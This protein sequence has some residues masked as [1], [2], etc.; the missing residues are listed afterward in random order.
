MSGTGQV[1][2]ANSSNASITT[3]PKRH[4][5][6]LDGLRGVAAITVVIFHLC[7]VYSYGNRLKLIPG[8]AYLAVDFFYLLSG[9]V[10]A[11]AYDDRWARMSQ[12]DFYKRRLIRLQPMVIL[13]T[14]IGAAL[15]YFPAGQRYPQIATT[16]VWQVLLLM[17]MGYVMLPVPIPYR[18][19]VKQEMFPLDL[20]V[21]SLFYEYIANVLYAV[22]LRRLS[23]RALGVLVFFCGI[24]LVQLAVFG[25][26]GDLIGGW[27]VA[28]N[29][30]YF[31]MVR[32]LF[33]FFAGI[34]LMRCG[35]RIHVKG[36]F[37]ICNALLLLALCMPRIG[38]AEHLWQ[39]GV[40]E[41][42]CVIV[43]FP[44]IVAMG[45]SERITDGVAIWLSRF[46]G[47]LSYPLYVTHVPLILIF[48]TWVVDHK[49][50]AARGAVVGTFVFLASVALAYAS[51]KL[52][53]EPVR[54]WLGRRFLPRA[55]KASGG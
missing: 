22:G 13:G 28:P 27:T 2:A 21:W 39:N 15:F 48:T 1:Q 10:V 8:H 19:H 6:I 55:Q 32:L 4:Y 45:A 37:W 31:G 52:Y 35:L 36:A 54:R 16:P 50:P 24:L 51:L 23:N 49:V 43:L 12:F 41:A 53:D 44:L 40:Y 30:L 14:T 3:V 5:L 46:F 9:F 20:A 38:G 29:Q 42:F 7:E 18:V 25:G 34:L 33:P 17:V 26:Q 11:Y 47:D